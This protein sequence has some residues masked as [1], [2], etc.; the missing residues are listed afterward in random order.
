MPV[1]ARAPRRSAAGGLGR[2]LPRSF[3]A[4]RVEVVA[5]ALLGRLFVVGRGSRRVCGRIVE[6]EAYAGPRDPASHAWRGPTPRNRAMFGPPG[7]LYVYL[8]YG[9][10][11][12]VNVVTGP[13]GHAGAV[14][15]R[16]L[17]PESGLPL[18]RRRRG[19]VPDRQLAR[20]PG[21]VGQATGLTTADDGADLVR[22]P[23]WVSERAPRRDGCR[24]ASG[25]RVGISRET[26]RPWRFF[27][28]GHPAVSAPGRE[29][30]RNP[31]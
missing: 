23:A 9:L 18:M 25:P 27:L 12:C 5:R 15:I 30:P 24:V 20:G 11:A 17:A 29:R 6:V 3:Y 13:A 8:S 10:H 1:P 19:G 26:A 21:C 7:H 14:L 31:R 4:R 2:P 16:A 22:G 28:A